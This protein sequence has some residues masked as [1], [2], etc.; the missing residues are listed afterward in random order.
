M[1]RSI[2]ASD[3][4]GVVAERLRMGRPVPGEV[5]VH[6]VRSQAPALL[7]MTVL[8]DGYP[9]TIEHVRYLPIVAELLGVGDMQYETAAVQL[10]VPEEIAVDRLYGR[11]G[12]SACGAACIV[13]GRCSTCGAHVE[14]PAPVGDFR[15]LVQEE[16]QALEPLHEALTRICP[17][18]TVDAS[19]PTRVVVAE[20]LSKL[21]FR[22]A[23]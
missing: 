11:S 2:A 13:A 14:R 9:R 8:F 21:S 16:L 4:E 17:L 7:G 18:Y 22:R 10:V 6:L 3:P 5:F 12:C 23:W 1:L 19:Q 20:V 15:T